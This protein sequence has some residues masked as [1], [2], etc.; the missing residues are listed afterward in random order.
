MFQLVV[1]AS[2]AS[3]PL[4]VGYYKKSC[5]GLENIV[6][7]TTT[8]FILRDRT[9][10]APLLRM[11]FHDCFVRGCDASVLLNSTSTNQAERDAI[12]NLSL[13]G[14]DVV[15]A[16]K[17]ALER[18]CPGVV[19]CADVLALVARD[20]VSLIYGPYWQVPVGRRDGNQSI[21]FEALTNLPPP[22]ANISTLI[23]MFGN[24]DLNVKDLVVLSGG[25]TLGISHCTSFTNRLYNFTGKGDTDPTLDPYYAVQLKKKCKPG[26]TTSFVSLDR[27]ATRFD[28]DYYTSVAKRRGLLQS[29][30]A[31]LDNRQTRNYVLTQSFFHGESFERDFGNSMIKMGKIGV[32]TGSNGQI[33]RKCALVN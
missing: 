31:L 13:R 14:F 25:H 12:P 4:K 21:A 30:A 5:P 2:A 28:E 32:L 9:L 15:D 29:D 24:K 23:T 19:S 20:A 7:R 17:E 11:H 33:R 1:A 26:D 6:K 16:A 3:S 8:K 27:T 22:F 18:E 10:A